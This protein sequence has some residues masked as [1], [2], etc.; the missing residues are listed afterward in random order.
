[1]I[2]V[3]VLV[4]LTSIALAPRAVF[5]LWYLDVVNATTPVRELHFLN[6]I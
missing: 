4:A 6:I 2:L 5:T 1:M 3:L